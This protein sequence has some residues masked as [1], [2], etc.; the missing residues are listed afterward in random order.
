MKAQKFPNGTAVHLTWIDS[1][2][3]MGWQRPRSNIKFGRINTMGYVTG[4]SKEGIA[5]SSS[6]GAIGSVLGPIFIPW[7]AVKE[8]HPLGPEHDV[9]FAA[10]LSEDS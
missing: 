2:T 1:V 5:I 4:C 6:H 8:V 10:K 9:G 3:T 7:L